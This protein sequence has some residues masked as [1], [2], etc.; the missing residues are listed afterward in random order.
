MVCEIASC[1]YQWEL[2]QD[3]GTLDLYYKK[4]TKRSSKMF[5]A[6]L[7]IGT[8]YK[9]QKTRSLCSLRTNL[10]IFNINVMQN[11]G[12]QFTKQEM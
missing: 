3:R 2:H 6:S 8:S 9:V 7:E 11:T 10:T 5:I 1:I 4:S 12:H